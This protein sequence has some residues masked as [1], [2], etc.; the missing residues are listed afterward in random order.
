MRVVAGK[1]RGATITA[2]KDAAVRPT[3]DRVREAMFNILAHG[4]EGFTLEDARVLDLFAGTGALGIEALS[5]GARFCL[6]IDDSA[7]ARALQRRNIEAL[8]LTGVTKV[9]RRDASRL[10][11][12]RGQDPFDCVFLDP[13]YGQSLGERSLAEALHGGWLVPNAVCVLEEKKDSEIVLPE[14]FEAEDRRT[15]G[16]TQVLFLRAKALS[17]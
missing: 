15:Y 6:F 17:D 1:F 13:P 10:G 2:P 11:P 14:G 8:D 3:S 9:W 4:L 7:D 12:L 5:R 16:D